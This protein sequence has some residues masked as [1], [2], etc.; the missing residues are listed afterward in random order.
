M[1]NT[2]DQSDL[3]L[4]QSTAQIYSDQSPPTLTEQIRILTEELE[5]SEVTNYNL[6]QSIDIYSKTINK[7]RLEAAHSTHII[8]L[9]KSTISFLRSKLKRTT[10]SLKNQISG[11]INSNSIHTLTSELNVALNTEVIRLREKINTSDRSNTE[12]EAI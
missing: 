3:E 8:S 12:T 6:K 2:D 4:I 10:Q 5:T 7:L 1:T 9:N 11:T